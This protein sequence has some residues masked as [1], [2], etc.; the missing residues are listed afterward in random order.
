M[1]MQIALIGVIFIVWISS[2][3][4]RRSVKA[5]FCVIIFEGILRKWVL[6]QASDMIYFLKDLII[7]GSYINYYFNHETKY[8]FKTNGLT[9]LLLLAT[10]WCLFQ[11]F[12]PSLG[13]PIVGFFGLKTYLFYIPLMWMFPTLFQSEDDLYKNLRNYL[14]LAIPVCLLSIAQFFSPVSSPINVY[15]GGQEATATLTGTAAVRVT[16][17]FPYIAGY[18]VYLSVC[19]S[20]LIPLLTVKQSSFWRAVTLV[21]AL[22]VAGTSFMTGARGLLLFEVLFLAG[23]AC[24]IGLTQPSL[25]ARCTKQII[26]PS[27]IISGAVSTFFRSAID[28]FFARSANSSPETFFDRALSA[29]A[30]PFQATSLKGLDGYGTGATHQAVSALRQVLNLRTGELPP[31]SEGET[32]R[33]VLELGPFGFL[34]WYG[35]RLVLIFSLWQVFLKLKKPF[36]RQLAL[37]GFLFQ[38]IQITGPVVFNNTFSLYY[39]FFSG[40]IFLLPQLERRDFLNDRQMVQ[41]QNV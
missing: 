12:N 19:F 26:L 5:V 22:L 2:L 36:L 34:F 13:S 30:E 21:E 40:L 14:V 15:A 24:V 28:A 32:G 9:V 23:Y 38:A 10:G 1:K 37:V 31:P 33:V 29:F 3:N 7:G 8:P 6:P 41:E 27:I 20:L 35:L 16:G 39:W 17:T 25:A 4:W 11:A 18:A